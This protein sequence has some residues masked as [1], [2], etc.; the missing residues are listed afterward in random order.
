[1]REHAEH[2]VG[3]DVAPEM[4]RV[5]REQATRRGVTG[6]EFRESLPDDGVEW[7]NSLVV[8]QHIAPE[9]GYPLLERL[10]ACLRPGGWC[11]LQ[12]SFFHDM[13]HTGEI[14]RDLGDYRYD[15][16]TIELVGGQNDYPEGAMSMYD[17]DL[18][19]VLR[20]LY[21][22]G[23]GHVLAEHTDHA[24]CHGAWLFGVRAPA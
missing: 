1:M 14:A 4:L 6:V 12:V 13:R 19:R 11:S 20:I 24:G 16:R 3:V 17:Y 9:L 7:I 22:A 2:V 18:N 23:V 15:G 8:F 10:V 5:G 21:R